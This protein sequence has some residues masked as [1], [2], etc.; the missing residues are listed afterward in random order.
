M[1]ID[2][3]ETKATGAAKGRR[4]EAKRTTENW[5]TA[6]LHRA[7]T[8]TSRTKINVRGAC[9]VSW[10]FRC[11]LCQCAKF[12]T[13]FKDLVS[14]AL[15]E[16]TSMQDMVHHTTIYLRYHTTIQDTSKLVGRNMN[17]SARSPAVEG[18]SG[19]E[20]I[21]FYQRTVGVGGK[22]A[23][24]V[25]ICRKSLRSQHSSVVRHAR[26]A[27]RCMS[28][29]LPCLCLGFEIPQSVRSLAL[30]LFRLCLH[31]L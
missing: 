21:E 7:S 24:S 8:P 16:S 23:F 27:L 20:S 5:A 2:N 9:S 29:A 14:C 22:L 12:M 31:Q 4:R 28:R 18:L 10:Q 13:S 25:F 15:C 3:D 6:I 19:W 17:A 11:I 1:A 26:V 30:V